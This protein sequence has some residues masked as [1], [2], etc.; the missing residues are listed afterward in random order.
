M[1][2]LNSLLGRTRLPKANEDRLF[3]MST[4]AI[5]LEA[6]GLKTAD[7]AGLVF[8]RLPPGRFERLEADLQQLLQLQGADSGVSVKTSTDAFGFE[9]LVL[10]GGGIQELLASMHSAAQ[11]LIEESLGD[12][13][14]AAVFR[15]DQGDRAIYWVYGYKQ[16]TFYPFVPLADRKRDNAEE[17]RL[18]SLAQEDLP[19]EKDPAL[20]YALWGAPL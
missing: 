8:K 9:W 12:L 14:L 4:A 20:W 15:F 5:G 18:A 2:L 7:R 1:G 6:G 19:V 13:L 10:V 17:I 11:S 3:A 16:G